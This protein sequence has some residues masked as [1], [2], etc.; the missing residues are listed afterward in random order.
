MITLSVIMPLYRAKYIAWLA[1]ES[2]ARQ[3][4]IDFE[5]ELIIMEEQQ[6]EQQTFRD[7]HNYIDRLKAIGC[8]RIAYTPIHYWIP[9]ANKTCQLIQQC[10]ST[11]KVLIAQAG[12]YYAPPKRLKRMHDIYEKNPV[13]D[14]VKVPKT[15][16]YDIETEQLYIHDTL[17]KAKFDS[18]C[19]A[20]LLKYARVIKSSEKKKGI[21]RWFAKQYEKVVG[22]LTIYIDQSSDWLYGLNVNGFNTISE[23]GKFF[24]S[25]EEYGFT[26][27]S[28]AIE[29]ILP[30]DILFFLRE[31]KKVLHLHKGKI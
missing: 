16:T 4:D 15:I 28:I 10:S 30:E 26:Q 22:E 2:L 9:L 24:E 31:S 23:R 5:W 20:V 8:S 29:N 1:Y 18:A 3:E 6:E 7:L 25:P 14:W 13:I 21:D 11:S 12:D 19:R 17:D 27:C